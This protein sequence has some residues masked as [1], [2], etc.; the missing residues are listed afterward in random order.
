[1]ENR[2]ACLPTT[3]PGQ[4]LPPHVVQRLALLQ[5]VCSSDF[6]S[7]LEAHLKT[8]AALC[9]DP[10]LEQKLL[11]EIQRQTRAEARKILAQEEIICDCLIVGTGP[12][13]V[14]LAA[15]LRELLPEVNMLMVDERGYRGGQFADEGYN[16]KLNTPR[17]G[18]IGFPGELKDPNNLGSGAFLQLQD[19]TGDEEYPPRKKLAT[20]LQVNGFIAAPALLGVKV[21]FTEVS[22]S[23]HNPYLVH[24]LDKETGKYFVLGSRVVAFAR[25]R[26]KPKYGQGLTV[27]DAQD[28]PARRERNVYVSEAFDAYTDSLSSQDLFNLIKN[29]LVFIGAGDSTNT[30]LDAILS[31]LL[32]AFSP[33]EIKELHIAVYG[34]KY[35]SG[36]DFEQVV[37]IP[38][39]NTLIPYIGTL[40][41][42]HAEKVQDLMFVAQ[43]GVGITTS[44]SMR[45]YNTVAMMTGQQNI[46]IEKL[47]NKPGGEAVKLVGVTGTDLLQGELIAQQ[48]EGENIFSVGV[49][50]Q[51]EFPGQPPV[52][53][54]SIVRHTP[55]ILAMAEKIADILRPTKDR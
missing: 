28:I 51:E 41:R 17:V 8:L 53:S 46:P 21:G 19:I 31:K 45:V 38:R 40:I 7:D 13:G 39:Y 27:L 47:V 36:L 25:G 4:S 43:G 48:V 6:S 42:P 33:E 14:S 20:C 54:R 15:K 26:G 24:A 11:E 35:T 37:R 44:T 50:V 2:D 30:A 22:G 18:R 9:K 55:R 34:A 12:A 23:S 1:M 16:Y 52:F 5:S 29:G 3:S 49:D 10:S 32:T